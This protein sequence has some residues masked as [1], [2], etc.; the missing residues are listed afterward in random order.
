MKLGYNEQRC[1]NGFKLVLPKRPVPLH[2]GAH[3]MAAL[4][5]RQKD[6]VRPRCFFCR[7]RQ[8]LL[9]SCSSLL[10]EFAMDR[11]IFTH[12]RFYLFGDTNTRFYL[13]KS[14]AANRRMTDLTTGTKPLE[15]RVRPLPSYSNN[16]SNEMSRLVAGCHFSEANML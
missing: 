4:S 5:P 16:L 7:K 3:R 9:R 15:E 2:Y 14:N 10:K 6:E 1:L 11:A 13:H 8:C 12:C